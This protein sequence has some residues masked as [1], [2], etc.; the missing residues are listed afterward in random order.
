MRPAT[1]PQPVKDAALA[2]AAIA[3]RRRPSERCPS[4]CWAEENGESCVV[5]LDAQ[6]MK[7]DEEQVVALEAV[8]GLVLEVVD[9][10][11]LHVAAIG[12]LLFGE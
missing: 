4:G 2:Q 1:I 12:E 5:A 9:R 10:R 11:A 7:L 3:I 8:L 6:M